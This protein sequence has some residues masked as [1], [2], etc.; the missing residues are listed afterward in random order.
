MGRLFAALVR[1]GDY[2]QLP[3]T[4]SAHQPFPLTPR[5]E[6]QAGAAAQILRGMLRKHAWQ[7]VPE[8]DSSMLLRAWETAHIIAGQLA[9]TVATDLHVT[10]FEALAERGLGSAANLSMTQICD[11]IHQDPRFPD[12]PANWKAD[13]HFRLPLQGAESL[14]EAGERVAKHLRQRMAALGP[15]GNRDRLKIFVG[16]GAALRHAA[17]HLGVLNMTQIAKLSM[18]HGQPVVLEFLQGGQWRHVEGDWKVREPAAVE[19]LD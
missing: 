5:G 14:L 1:H 2:H 10:S 18:Y 11:V 12:L 8:V 13:S 3:D 7:P 19:E 4:P 9:D 6:E 15:A 16:H 17:Y